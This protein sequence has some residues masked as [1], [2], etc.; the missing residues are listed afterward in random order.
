MK[1]LSVFALLI[2]LMSCSG[3][4]QDEKVAEE[5]KVDHT[6][7]HIPA[8][9]QVF[10]AHGG[11]EN[12]AKLKTLSYQSGGSKTLVDL[13]NRYT[14]IESENQT[15]GF[16]G[17][18][19]W[20]YPPSENADKQRMRYN[21]MFYFYAFPFVVGD[22]GV[23]YEVL[24]PLDLA[25]KTYNAV[26]VSYNS[27]VGDSPNDSYIICSDPETDQMQWLMYTATF[28]G[29]SKDRFNLIKYEGWQN[30]NGVILPTSLQ[31]YGYA[32]GLVGEPRGEATTFEN[33]EVAEAYPAMSNFEMPE[34]ASVANMPEGN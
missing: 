7:H 23:N 13:Q 3:A 11:F 20:V 26:K 29:E 6:A 14:R 8:I 34:G 18:R 12:W 2:F 33:I 15:V 22:P 30:F 19:V 9:T 4:K 31:W 27:G 28:G 17:E 21:L 32:D 1:K 10:D 16:D 24:E 5:P 25:G